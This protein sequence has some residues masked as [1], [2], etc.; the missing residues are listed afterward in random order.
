M[1]GPRGVG[2]DSPDLGDI[3]PTSPSP[4][5]IG[6][7]SPDLGGAGSA[8]PKC[9]GPTGGPAPFSTITDMKARI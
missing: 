3:G 4:G 9:V 5:G 2:F 8:S 6:T 1:S 7:I